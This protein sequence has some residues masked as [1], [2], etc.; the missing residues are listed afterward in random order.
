MVTL[1]V[2]LFVWTPRRRLGKTN[3]RIK[4]AREIIGHKLNDRIK[5]PGD[6]KREKKIQ[7]KSW[8]S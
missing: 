7:E 6:G 2:K 5:I 1:K 4:L 3:Y 8:E